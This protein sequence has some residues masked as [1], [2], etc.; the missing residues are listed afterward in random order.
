MES[1]TIYAWHTAYRAAVLET[2]PHQMPARIDTAL[3]AITERLN[4]AELSAEER[5]EIENAR[6]SLTVLH[7]ERANGHSKASS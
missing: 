7:W 6:E 5:A 4:T 2:D 1:S 3:Q